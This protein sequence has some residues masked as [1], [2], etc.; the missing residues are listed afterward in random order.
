MD[1]SVLMKRERKKAIIETK[2]HFLQGNSRSG[3][4]DVTGYRQIW[5]TKGS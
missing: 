2:G 3:K 1:N 5:E 4:R